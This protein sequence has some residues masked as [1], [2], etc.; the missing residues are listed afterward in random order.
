MKNFKLILAAVAMTALVCACG[1]SND[2]PTPAPQPNPNPGAGTFKGVIFAT[3]VTNPEGNSGASYMQALT[4]L[5][6]GTYDNSNA[7]PV[8]FGTKPIATASGNVYVLPD[9]MGNTKPELNRYQIDAAGK[10]I[11][12]GT[13]LLPANAAACN[14]VELN[15]EKAYVSLQGLGIVMAFNPTTMKKLADIDLNDLKQTETK[16]SPAA[17]IVRDGKLFVGLNQMNAQYMPARNN[18][19]LAM[20]DTKTDKVEKHIVNT[21]L[22]MCFATRPIDPQSI[23]MDEQKDIYLNCIGS[24][25]FILG[26]N[27]GVVRIKNGATDI[28]PDYSIRLDKTEIA[29]LSTKHAEFLG[30]VCYAGDGK[31]YAYANSY[32]LDPNAKTNPY[33]SI[34]NVPIV[35]D[36]KQK[37][38]SVIKGMEISNPHGIAIGRHKGLIVFG[39]ANKKANG[40]YTYD[41]TTKQVAGPVMRVTGN[42]CYFHS[43]VK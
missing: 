14:I 43:F 37:T 29:G 21:T 34:T 40:F 16:V 7:L 24:F 39:S 1:S 33:L 41:P 12:K 15:N 11:K 2:D 31:L 27:G 5:L 3:S 13:L 32:G 25:G 6:P 38:M 26:L 8:G 20:I 22:G 18:I 4:D 35:I 17:M 23:F 10:W 36:L 19:E 9:Y 30:E 28:D 42:P